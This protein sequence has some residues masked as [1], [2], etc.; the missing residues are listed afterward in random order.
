MASTIH[1]H[2][3]SK[4]LH[5]KTTREPSKRHIGILVGEDILRVLGESLGGHNKLVE[6]IGCHV[7]AV[8]ASVADI[9]AERHG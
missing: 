9:R 4:M 6:F 7:R 8:R 2:P 1:K 3:A 5:T